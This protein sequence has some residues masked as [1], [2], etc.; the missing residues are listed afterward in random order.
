MASKTLS[1]T[2]PGQ[3]VIPRPSPLRRW[4]L[5]GLPLLAL[6]LL[7]LAGGWYLQAQDAAKRIGSGVQVQDVPVAGLT[8]PQAE[9]AITARYAAPADQPLVLT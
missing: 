1:T 5:I 6:L 2:P 9:A 3:A 8:V 7:A 4:A